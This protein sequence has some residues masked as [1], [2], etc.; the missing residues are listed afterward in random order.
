MTDSSENFD[1]ILTKYKTAGEVSAKA[2]RT[3][4][5]AAT[6]GKTVLELMQIGDEAVEP[7]SYTHLT[8]PTI[9]SV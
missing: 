4:I 6:E 9:C 2:M 8:L 5:D 3:V 1:V 7:V